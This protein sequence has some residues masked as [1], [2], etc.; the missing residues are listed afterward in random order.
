MI[1][2]FFDQYP[3]FQETSRTTPQ[4]NRLNSRY[5]ALIDRHRGLLKGARALDLASHDGRWSFAALKSGVARVTGVEGRQYLIDN[6]NQTFREY[7]VDSSTFR[8]IQ[9]DVRDIANLFAPGEFDVIF[10]FGILYHVPDPMGLL[11]AA[12]ALGPRQII[13][14]THISTLEAAVIELRYDEPVKESDAIPS[15]EGKERVIVGYPSVAAMRMVLDNLGYASEL[16]DYAA[17]GVTD[18]SF[19]EDYMTGIRVSMLAEKNS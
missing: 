2:P 15:P 7:G 17:V 12:A 18:W 8:F 11:Q 14:D 9:G 10:I 6:A 13:I 16:I 5:A 1:Q 4:L 19:I 3:R